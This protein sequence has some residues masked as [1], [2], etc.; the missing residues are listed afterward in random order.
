MND[1]KLER[2]KLEPNR[3][4]YLDVQDSRLYDSLKDDDSWM[5]VE[6]R[7]LLTEKARNSMLAHRA[8]KY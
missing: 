1:F 5:S 6:I 8:C 7:R 3:Y 2:S 4:D